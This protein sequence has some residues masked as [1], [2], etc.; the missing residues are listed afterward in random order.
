MSGISPEFIMYGFKK[1]LT[2]YSWMQL[3]HVLHNMISS[4]QLIG[5]S[6]VLRHIFCPNLE[7]LTSISGDLSRRQAQNQV[8]FYF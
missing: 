3:W 4:P 7:I 6:T 1:N 8:N 5:T 2:E